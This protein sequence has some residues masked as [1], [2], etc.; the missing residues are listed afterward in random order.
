MAYLIE[1]YLG[2]VSLEDVMLG[3]VKPLDKNS[4]A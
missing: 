3:K 2:S 4:L 1:Q